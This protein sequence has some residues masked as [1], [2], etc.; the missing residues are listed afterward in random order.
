MFKDLKEDEVSVLY[1]I[2]NLSPKGFRYFK[3]DN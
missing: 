2:T 3:L 1:Q